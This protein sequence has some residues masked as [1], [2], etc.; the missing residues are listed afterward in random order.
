MNGTGS[1]TRECSLGRS[2]VDTHCIESQDVTGVSCS[3]QQ[4]CLRSARPSW[5]TAEE[6][7]GDSN[8]LNLGGYDSSFARSSEHAKPHKVS[9]SIL[10]AGDVENDSNSSQRMPLTVAVEGSNAG[11]AEPSMQEP[12]RRTRKLPDAPLSKQSTQSRPSTCPDS[13]Q[14][15]LKGL[16]DLQVPGNPKP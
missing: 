1:D 11:R 10:P 16:D 12:R 3:T 15:M 6:T 13:R 14:A 2:S 9:E 8:L 4:S 7:W 5:L